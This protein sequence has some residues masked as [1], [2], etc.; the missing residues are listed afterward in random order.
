[1]NIFG[2]NFNFGR[3]PQPIQPPTNPNLMR[4][5]ITTSPGIV[6][7]E[8]N[9]RCCFL[10]LGNDKLM[11][12]AQALTKDTTQIEQDAMDRLDGKR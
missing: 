2:I 9:K 11:S 3:Q 4:V 6:R 7:F 8:F 1:M 10:K 5:R 12:A